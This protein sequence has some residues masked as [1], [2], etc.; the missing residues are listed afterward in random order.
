MRRS[1]TTSVLLGVLATAAALV[2][3]ASAGTTKNLTYHSRGTAVTPGA[4]A[5]LGSPGTYEDF[6]FTIAKGDENGSVSIV[7]NWS[8]PTDDWDLYV[9]RKTAKGTLDTVG[10]SAGGPPSTQEAAVIQASGGPVAPGNYIVRA[11]NYAA[12][13]PDFSGFVKF[14]KF[15]HPNRAPI[16]VLHAPRTAKAG[17]RVTL[18]ASKSHDPDGHLVNFSWDLNDDG[19]MEVNGHRNG[20]LVRKFGAGVHYVTVR[21]TDSRGA[22][23]YANARI[24][25]S[26]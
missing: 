7:L 24:V 18:N 25:V 6:P 9:Y 17:R 2:P 3:A 1:R 15:V 26:R 5:G 14:G 12:T 16:A 8:N 22:R 13:S 4:V 20:R 11:Q 19:A 21:V 23:A 10:N